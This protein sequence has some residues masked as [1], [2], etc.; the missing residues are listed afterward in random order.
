MPLNLEL[1]AVMNDAHKRPG[2]SPRRILATFV[3]WISLPV[4]LL[5]PSLSSSAT[6]T[7]VWGPR[8]LV[9]TVSPLASEAGASILRQGGNAADAA[10]AVGFALAVTWPAAGNL[11]G[12]GFALVRSQDGK[13]SFI[14][15]R[16]TAPAAA[17]KNFYLDAKGEVIPG[18]S[19]TGYR[20][21]G[22]PGT[23]AGMALL[24]KK[25][26][27]LPWK[28]VI[29]PARRLA[30]EGF[31]VDESFASM[32]EAGR[33]RLA[34][35]PGSK[36]IFLK[37]GKGFKVGDRFKQ[38]ELGWSLAQI[39]KAGESAF[40]TGPI[41]KRL[42]QAIQKGGGVMTLDDLKNYKVVDRAPL[43]GR[44]KNY[45][46]VTAPPPS[47]GGA[48]LLAMLGMLE[49]DDL[50]ALGFGSAAYNHLL[51]ETMKRAFADRS[52]WFGDPD[53]V[54]NPLQKFLDPAYLAKRRAG[55]QLTKA[56]PSQEIKPGDFSDKEST[57]TTH[58]TIVD[59]QGMIISNTY[60]LNGS[61]GS[62]VTAD[63][64]GILLNN[65]MDDFSSKP[66]SPNMY[67]LLQSDRNA[68]APKKRPLSSMTPTIILDEGK[69]LLA[70]GSPG[71][72]TIINS[73]FQV[74]LN[75][76]VFGMNIQA[77]IDAPKL[78]HQWMPDR[79]LYEPFGVNPDTQKIMQGMGHNFG[80]RSFQFGDVQAV[81]YDKKRQQWSGGSDSRHGGSVAVE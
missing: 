25:Y 70:L 76:L 2:F 62:G 71:G 9:A 66:G 13:S 47:S 16:E 61:F 74:T 60:T 5:Q 40:Y 39:Q 56:T 67:G 23:V 41:A 4:F 46:I 78:H 15:Y 19:T 63:G 28:K 42:I 20:A 1:N 53:F 48:L 81:L 49:K 34:K 27:K 75:A 14:D 55:I 30:V 29:E 59:A 31:I 6:R 3:L 68:I 8:G 21:V 37:D 24:H 11:G 12:G 35:F 26:G 73:V 72:P 52:E 79:I 44:Y 58:Y 43:V 64:T 22:T 80:D 17:D 45:Q 57:E 10:V 69:P 50:A 65:E 33:D 54:Q 36:H 51:I 77:A 32:L 18:A 38:P 7:P